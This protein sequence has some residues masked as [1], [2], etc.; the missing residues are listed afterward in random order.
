M[1][2]QT[3]LAVYSLLSLGLKEQWF[4]ISHFYLNFVFTLPI[5][6]PASLA[7]IDSFGYTDILRRN[8]P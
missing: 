2:D 6:V 1:V 3:W 5:I 8:S 7:F 4:I